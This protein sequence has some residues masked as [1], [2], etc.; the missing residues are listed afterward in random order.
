MIIYV[1][2]SV[3]FI[4]SQLVR[5][6]Q[7]HII[8]RVAQTRIANLI[9]TMWKATLYVDVFDTIFFLDLQIATSHDILLY[10]YCSI[11]QCALKCGTNFT[12]TSSSICSP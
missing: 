11:C 7:L 10:S 8:N 2:L 6:R 12:S 5:L 1:H 3:S 4:E 9:G